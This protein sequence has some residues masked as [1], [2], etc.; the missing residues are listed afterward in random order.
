M[1]TI[2]H[3]LVSRWPLLLRYKKYNQRKS[4][5]TFW[6]KTLASWKLPPLFLISLLHDVMMAFSSFFSFWTAMWFS[7]NSR[8]FS[9]VLSSAINTSNQLNKSW[10]EKKAWCFNFWLPLL[11]VDVNWQHNFPVR[12]SANHSE[13]LIRKENKLIKNRVLDRKCVRHWKVTSFLLV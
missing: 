5:N 7:H 11:I 12:A 6:L 2:C 1:V 3:E 9:C 10:P 13:L 8:H 4:E